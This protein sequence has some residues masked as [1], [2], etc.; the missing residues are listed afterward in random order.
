MKLLHFTSRLG[1][2]FSYSTTAQD[3]APLFEYLWQLAM[4]ALSSRVFTILLF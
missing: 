4:F 2:N 1:F 3:E